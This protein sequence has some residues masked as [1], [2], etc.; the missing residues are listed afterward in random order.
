MILL[1]FFVQPP[2]RLQRCRGR[3][4]SAWRQAGGNERSRIFPGN[5]NVTWPTPIRYRIAVSNPRATFVAF[6]SS[7]TPAGEYR[8]GCVFRTFSVAFRNTVLQCAEV[9]PAMLSDRILV[10][11]H[12]WWPNSDEYDIYRSTQA[13]AVI[14]SYRKLQS[15]QP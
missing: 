4:A 7:P 8:V 10:M 15:R 12:L 1:F 6:D 13:Q 9:K 11:V 2:Y 3:I 5:R 14:E